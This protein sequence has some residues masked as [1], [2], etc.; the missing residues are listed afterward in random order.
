[1]SAEP[2]GPIAA[3][4]STSDHPQPLAHRARHHDRHHRARHRSEIAEFLRHL[5]RFRSP[6]ARRRPDRSRPRLLGHART[7]LFARIA[8]QHARPDRPH[9][10]RRH[11]RRHRR[12]PKSTSEHPDHR[13]ADHRQQRADRGAARAEAGRDAADPRRPRWPR[14]APG[15]SGTWS[16][17]R[18]SA[19]TRS[20]GASTT[21]IARR[22][23]RARFEETLTLEGFD[24]AAAPKLPRRA[25]PRPGRAALAPGRRVGDPLRPGRGREN[26]RRAS[27]RAPGDPRRRRGPLRQDQPR[28]W[29]S[30]PAGHAD[31]TWTRRLRELARPAV[32]VLTYPDHAVI[33]NASFQPQKALL[34]VGFVSR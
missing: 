22:T 12:H 13:H 6:A 27:P 33:P 8:D 19:T 20:P 16:S 14:P 28:P 21:A 30:S 10:R 24:F 31:G 29:P 26:P 1:M 5:A 23:R 3:D 34:R 18:S 4:R 7:E 11:T 25:D 9:P 15:S 32:L 17:C 2:T